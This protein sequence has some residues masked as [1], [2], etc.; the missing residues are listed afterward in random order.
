MISHIR[1]LST[2]LPIFVLW[3]TILISAVSA[4]SSI[5][6]HHHQHRCKP[7]P[8]SHTSAFTISLNPWVNIEGRHYGKD[9]FSTELPASHKLPFGPSKRSMERQPN[10]RSARQASFTPLHADFTASA[11]SLEAD[12]EQQHHQATAR[13]LP[14]F[15]QCIMKFFCIAPEKDGLSMRQR[16]T[17]MGIF[18]AMS[19]NVISH[20]NS[21]TTMTIAYYLYSTRTGLSPLEA[22]QWK[23][24]LGF[25]AG[26]WVFNNFL[27]PLRIAGAVA[28]TPRMEALTIRVQ[29][30]FQLSRTKAIALTGV[31]TYL[32]ALSY[33]TICM[34]LA[35]T[36]SGVPILA[37]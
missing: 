13:T 24:F 28:L 33:T 19:Y 34:A 23:G 3:N 16:L 9:R 12:L 6:S 17:K 5:G 10:H 32:A 30:R 15:A 31:A 8:L 18:A 21:G 4:Y 29:S 35:S 7:R 37:K 14:T 27:R 26:F 11:D 22:D 1:S 36:L 25:Y 2:N 20:V